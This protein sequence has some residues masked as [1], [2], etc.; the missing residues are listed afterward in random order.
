MDEAARLVTVT[1]ENVDQERFFC[2]KSKPKTEGYLNKRTWLEDRF[3]EGLAI[4]MI[5]EGKRSV[6][7]IETIPGEYAWRAVDASDYLVIHCL[8]V[9]GKGKGKRYAGWLL[10]ACEEDAHRQGKAGVVMVASEGNWL[11]GKEA[12]LRYGYEIVEEAPPSFSLLVKRFDPHDRLPSF[13]GNWEAKAKRFGEGATILYADQCPYMPDAVSGAVKIFEDRGI[14][15]RAV[16]METVEEVRV[17]SPT[18][19]GVFAIIL[20][21]E[22]FAYHYL[23]DKEVKQLDM[24]LA[25]G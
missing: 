1:A 2:Y 4:R 3:A 17:L 15:V 9:V 6:A 11:C 5:Y 20:N 13:T 8:W 19:Y 12:F 7:F 14:P 25:G 21:G 22:V 10:E 18:P 16:K 23:L 24:L